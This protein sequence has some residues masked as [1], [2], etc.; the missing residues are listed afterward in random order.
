MAQRWYQKA[1]VQTAIVTGVF[2]VVATIIGIV[3][4][5]RDTSVGPRPNDSTAQHSAVRE[6]PQST[7]PLVDAPY[8]QIGL[9]QRTRLR[10]GLRSLTVAES[11][12]LAS[13]LPFSIYGYAHSLI[14]REQDTEIH[15]VPT[16]GRL[17]FEAQKTADGVVLALVFVNLDTQGILSLNRNVTVPTTLYS[18]YWDEA[19]YAVLVVPTSCNGTSRVIDLDDGSHVN[20]VDCEP[21]ADKT[22][23]G[24]SRT[25]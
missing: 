24:A 21:V 2:L 9:S 17:S 20:A 23:K 1:G 10:T 15:R 22:P 8:S 5:R 13:K 14:F 25:P 16:Y 19:K 3:L 4:Q 11:G 18:D 7:Q 6:Y 12:R